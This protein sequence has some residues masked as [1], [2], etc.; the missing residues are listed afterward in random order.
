MIL[1]STFYHKRIWLV[2]GAYAEPFNYYIEKK[3]SQKNPTKE[4]A[5]FYEK[6][7]KLFTIEK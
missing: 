2:L 3:R 7:K 1:Y 4:E 5:L 6:K